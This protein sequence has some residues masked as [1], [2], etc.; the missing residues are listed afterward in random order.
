MDGL[1]LSQLQ[2]M[3]RIVVSPQEMPLRTRNAADLLDKERAKAFLRE[4]RDD[5]QA[6]SLIVSASIFFKR[7]LALLSGALYCMSHH[8]FA[9]NL[10]LGN[11]TLATDTDWKMASFSLKQAEGLRKVSTNRDKWRSQA[12]HHFFHDMLAPVIQALSSHTGIRKTVLWAHTAYIVR[13]YYE[14]WQREAQLVERREQIAEDFRFLLEE[15][16]PQLFGVK[17]KNPLQLDFAIA[18]HPSDPDHPIRIRKQ[19]CLA[20]RLAQGKCCY[21]CPLLS[22]DKRA[23]QILA[24]GI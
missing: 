18:E 8:S 11:I 6:P 4:V 14:L 16:H 9:L 24:A 21:T 15:A 13:Y 22:E 3:F 10:S 23:E 7:Y 17:D 12:V 19:C 5:L 20:Y 1:D 2:S